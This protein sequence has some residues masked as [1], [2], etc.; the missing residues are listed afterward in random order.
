MRSKSL[1]EFVL[2]L[3]REEDVQAPIGTEAGQ[4]LVTWLGPKSCRVDTGSETVECRL[5]RA[6][7]VAIGDKVAFAPSAESLIISKVRPRTTVLSRPDVGNSNLERVIAANIDVVVV[8]V[9]VVAPPLHPKII[10][11]YMI[12]IQK[13]RSQDASCRK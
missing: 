2:Q 12:A 8:A 6:G 4:G 9:S 5:V 1:D 3:L 7:Q 13:G 10:D 11:R